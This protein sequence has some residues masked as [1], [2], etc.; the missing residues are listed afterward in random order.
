MLEWIRVQGFRAGRDEGSRFWGW[1]GLGF[2]VL[3]LDWIRVRG[4]G[5]GR[6]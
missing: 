1:K 2:E 5:A 3:G 6:D 4:F